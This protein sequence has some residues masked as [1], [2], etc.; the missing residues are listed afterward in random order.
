[1]KTYLLP[2][3]LK[4]ELRKI[5]GRPILGRKKEVERKFEILLKKK[6]VKKIITVGDICSLNLPSNIKIFDGKVKR[7]RIKNILNFSLSFKNP[8]GTIQKEAWKKTKLA[9]KKNRNVF[10]DGEEDLL[11]IPAVLLSPKGSLVVYGLPNKGIC[12][13]EVKKRVKRKIK[14]LLERFQSRNLL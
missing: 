13:I 9:I 4:P 2:E 14:K 6:R 1:M 12:T 3:N 10:V 5:W 11:V 8:A 7:K